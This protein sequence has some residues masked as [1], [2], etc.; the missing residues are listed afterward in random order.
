MKQDFILQ[1]HRLS[2]EFGGFFAVK[3]V[4]LRV[5]RGTIHALIGPNGAGKSTC[6]NLLTRFLPAT[7]GQILYDGCDITRTS[8]SALPGMGLGR[9]FQISSIFPHLTLLENVRVALQR[10]ANTQYRF[11][12]RS[13]TLR[14]FDDRAMSLL[15]SVG[16]ADYAKRRAVELSY[17]RRRAL[18]LATTLALDP[19][20]L[21][22]DEPMA[23]VGHEDIGRLAALIGD[24]GR[25]RTVLMVEHNLDVVADICNQVTVMRRGEILAEGCYDEV[26]KNPLVISAYMGEDH[27]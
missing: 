23:G 14:V 19:T 17:G 13:R 10:K 20:M 27:E 3:D 4:D 8:P 9:S 1:T 2:R 11:W 21:L 24:I 16:L 18:E 12:Q 6:F 15:E 7:S 5:R 25:A 22:L 26:S